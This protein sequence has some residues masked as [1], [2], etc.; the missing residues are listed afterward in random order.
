[1]KALIYL[2]SFIYGASIVYCLMC[3]ISL[4]DK[5]RTLE[6][7]Y[8]ELKKTIEDKSNKKKSNHMK[9]YEGDN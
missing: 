8:E 3:V 9:L 6:Y 1:M 2:S 5:Y 4:S 7:K